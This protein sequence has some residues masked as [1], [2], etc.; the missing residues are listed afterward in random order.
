MKT[1]AQLANMVMEHR[2]SL[3]VD[4]V[5][6]ALKREDWTLEEVKDRGTLTYFGPNECLF[7]F[8]G[9]P[10]LELYMTLDFQV[11]DE[12]YFQISHTNYR[13]LYDGK[14]K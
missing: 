7:M 6:H 3:I 10:L 2:E 9:Q 14:T 4:A 11:H 8:D 12:Q 1:T 13:K 5:N